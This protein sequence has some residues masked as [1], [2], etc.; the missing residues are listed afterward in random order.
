MNTMNHA[1]FIIHNKQQF[2]LS[3]GKKLYYFAPGGILNLD[4]WDY[5][6]VCYQLNHWALKDPAIFSPKLWLTPFLL[7]VTSMFGS[8]V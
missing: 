5:K 1:P 4:I 6:Q 8:T 7:L 3:L 2:G